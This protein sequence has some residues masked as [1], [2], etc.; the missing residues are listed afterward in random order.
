MNRYHIT[1]WIG[2]IFI[3]AVTVAAFGGF[4]LRILHDLCIL[5]AIAT[6]AYFFIR[7]ARTLRRRA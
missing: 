2:V 5:L 3:V 1:D 6:T 7:V 4:G